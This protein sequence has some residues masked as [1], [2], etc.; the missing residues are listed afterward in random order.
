VATVTFQHLDSTPR[1]RPRRLG[2]LDRPDQPPVVRH[3]DQPNRIQVEFSEA[4]VEPGSATPDETF[5]V[6]DP[7]GNKLR[8][9]TFGAPGNMVVWLGDDFASF[10]AGPH[11]VLLIGDGPPAIAATNGTRL[12]GEFIEPLSVKPSGDGTEGGDFVF[13]FRV[14]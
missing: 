5:I 7:G 12:D 11:Q 10:E 4:V 2:T 8:G 14:G 3:N 6:L 13:E 1:A 9:Q